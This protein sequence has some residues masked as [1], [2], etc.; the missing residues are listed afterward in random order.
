MQIIAKL[1]ARPALFSFK[2]IVSAADG[3]ILSR[4]NLGLDVP[5]EKMALVQKAVISNCNIMVQQHQRGISCC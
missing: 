3:V 4:G 5:P 2:S 1:E